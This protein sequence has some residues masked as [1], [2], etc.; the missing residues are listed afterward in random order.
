MILACDKCHEQHRKET[1]T[2]VDKFSFLFNK[3]YLE[4]F[5]DD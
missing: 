2:N 1:W 4:G 3:S 5:Y